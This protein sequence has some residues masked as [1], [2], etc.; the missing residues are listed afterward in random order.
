MLHKFL[1]TCHCTICA[2]SGLECAER[3]LQ[4]N[5]LP[6]VRA[7]PLSPA[8]CPLVE[9]SQSPGHRSQACLAPVP[10]LLLH[11]IHRLVPAGGIRRDRTRDLTVLLHK[12]LCARRSALCADSTVACACRFMQ[13]DRG[14]PGSIPPDATRRCKPG[15][16]ACSCGGERASSSSRWQGVRL[17]QAHKSR[18]FMRA[19][20]HRLHRRRSGDGVKIYAARPAGPCRARSDESGD[21]LAAQAGG[22]AGGRRVGCHPTAEHALGRPR[23]GPRPKR[24]RRLR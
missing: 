1:C 21:R 11:W 5:C 2:D 20:L 8:Q 10:R 14:V 22:R 6:R 17:W 12:S 4:Q 23:A 16:V 3:F 7:A 13:Q 18:F 15:R 24:E 19:P 9:N